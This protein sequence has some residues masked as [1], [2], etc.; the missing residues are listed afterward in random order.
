MCAIAGIWQMDGR[1]VELATIERFIGALAH[2]GPDGQSLSIADDGRLALAHRRLA[3][4]DLSEAGRQPMRSASGRYEIIYNGEVYNFL[5]LRSELA[6]DGF[7]FRG[8]SD[9]EVLLAAFEKW[10]PGCLLRFNGMW[11]LAIWDRRDRTL[12][13][14]RDRF[15]V[16]PLY[17]AAGAQR[18][19]FASELKAFLQLEDF[20]A[21]ADTDVV[22]KRLAGDFADG[23]LLR[24]VECLPP[25]YCME[26]TAE[27]VR[28]RRWWNTLDHLVAVPPDLPRQAARLRELLFDSCRLRRRSDVPIATSLSGGLDSSSVLCSMAATRQQ[29]V[30]PRDSPDWRRAFIAGFPGTPQDET[31]YAMLASKQADAVPVIRRFSGDDF[32]ESVD[33][34][35]YQFEEI[36]GLSGIASWALY[37]EMR[38]QDVRVSLD[39]HGGD[40]LLGGYGLHI[41]LALMRSGSIVSSPRRTLDLIDTLQHMESPRKA[42]ASGNKALLAAWTVPAVRAIARRM[43]IVGPRQR[44]LAEMLKRHSS[45]SAAG[46]DE[47]R[48]AEE[49]AIDE[50]GPLTAVLYRSFHRTSLPRILRNF[51]VYSMAHGVEVRMPLLDW[52]LV[53]YVFSIPDE[54]KVSGG[55]AKLLLRE[56]MRGV[57]PEAVRLR[58]DKLGYNAPVVHWMGSGFDKWMWDALNDREFLRS[59]L[60][61]GAALLKLATRLRKSNTPWHPEQMRR[62][63]RALTAHSWLTNWLRRGRGAAKSRAA[64]IDSAGGRGAPA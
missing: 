24:G 42:R 31:R 14:A 36:G 4:L 52:R 11:S 23:V 13:L 16:K 39:G 43:P 54:S 64:A 7:R 34:Y 40:E 3:I 60:W 28:P 9:T 5:E 35:L 58:R 32:R 21:I 56:A 44:A 50:L 30:A 20:E 2:R 18:L 37:R 12:F 25:G 59:D 41:M 38:R 33:D 51:D 27:R 1:K 48:L 8:Q 26:V 45:D 22:R 49:R 6:R 61:D 10:G 29:D 46:N 19:A 63:T 55:Y 17:I 53:C 47:A 62:V 15:G 57:L